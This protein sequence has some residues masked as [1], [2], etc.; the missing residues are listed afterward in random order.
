[1]I[2]VSPTLPCKI[3]FS[4]YDLIRKRSHEPRS[5]AQESIP[6]IKAQKAQGRLRRSHRQPLLPLPSVSSPLYLFVFE[7]CSPLSAEWSTAAQWDVRLQADVTLVQSGAPFWSWAP[8]M[9]N[10]FSMDLQLDLWS[11][12]FLFDALKCPAE[13]KLQN[14]EYI[15]PV[16]LKRMLKDRLYHNSVMTFWCAKTHLHS[17]RYFRPVHTHANYPVFVSHR[18]EY[19]LQ[20]QE[21]TGTVTAAF[22]SVLMFPPAAPRRISAEGHNCVKLNR[23]GRAGQEVTHWNSIVHTV[24]FQNKT[25]GTVLGSCLTSWHWTFKYIY[26]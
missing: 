24:N 4:D 5:A 15:S 3:Q 23:A 20:P 18:E 22:Q 7:R 11:F 21:S 13:Y 19:T 6:S 14:H 12:S 1:M 9:F 26:I 8:L 17:C 10:V 16:V 25:P 2:N